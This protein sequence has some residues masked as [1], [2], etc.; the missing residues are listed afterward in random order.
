VHFADYCVS[1][2][3]SELGCNLA[4][5]KS[6]FPEF[7]QLLDALVGPGQYRHRILPSAS[8][9]PARER[10]CDAKSPKNPSTQNPLALAGRE[11]RA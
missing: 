4:G 1:G 7:L 9:R 10:R 11:K 2:H 8:R 6:G 3:I 5:R